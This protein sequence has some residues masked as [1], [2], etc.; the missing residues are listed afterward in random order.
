[1][2]LTLV[3]WHHCGSVQTCGAYLVILWHEVGR[4]VTASAECNIVCSSLT[5]RES[6]MNLDFKCIS[7]FRIS[8][9]VR[10]Y[11]KFGNKLADL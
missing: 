9:V 3:Q 7:N 4:D 5:Q 10:I 1:M 6:F 11:R 8:F 2:L